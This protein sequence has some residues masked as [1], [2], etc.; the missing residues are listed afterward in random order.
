MRRSQIRVL[1]SLCIAAGVLC[2][3]APVA[4]AR[5][6]YLRSASG[7]TP[8]VNPYARLKKRD[9]V[10]RI[11]ARSAADAKIEAFVQVFCFDRKNR[12]FTKRKTFTGTG[13]VTGK[14]RRPKRKRLSCSTSASVK[15]T[16]RSA[17]LQGPIPPVRLS[18]ALY[19]SR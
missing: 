19:A 3:L 18:A 17:P 7:I 8:Q 1:A 13:R 6:V 15:V 14:L 9:R 12:V 5:R 10:V 2:A 16:S 11:S 4:G